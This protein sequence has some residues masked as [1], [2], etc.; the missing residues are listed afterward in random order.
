MTAFPYAPVGVL[1]GCLLFGAMLLLIALTVAGTT[2]WPA[3]FGLV[4]AAAMVLF[5]TV[6]PSRDVDV[7]GGGGLN[8]V[9]LDSI[10]HMYRTNPNR[11]LVA[12]NLLG[13]VLMFV[14]IGFFAA[15]L[16]P[17]NMKRNAAEIKAGAGFASAACVGLVFTSSIELYQ[18]RAG[19]VFDIDDMLLNVVGSLF[20]GLV[21]FLALKIFNTWLTKESKNATEARIRPT[22]V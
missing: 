11:A 10:V 12:L 6:G 3:I 18:L 20:G 2:K 13:N 8:L 19:R 14:P 22:S 17:R 9:P 1:I 21:A 16:A 15:T 5:V 7:G 4:T